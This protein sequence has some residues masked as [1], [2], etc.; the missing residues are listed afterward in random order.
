MSDSLAIVKPMNPQQQKP[1][2]QAVVDHFG[3]RFQLAKAIG[4]TRAAV[5]NWRSVPDHW[6]DTIADLMT[7]EWTPDGEPRPM[8]LKPVPSA[9]Q[10]RRRRAGAI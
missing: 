7:A 8:L 6:V 10:P 3:S 1:D 4:I 2:F 5:Y 9:S